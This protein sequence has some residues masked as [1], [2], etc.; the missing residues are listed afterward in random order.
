MC[1][2]PID[3]N[4]YSVGIHRAAKVKQNFPKL[5]KYN[6][7]HLYTHSVIYYD[8]QHVL[9]RL[10][11]AVKSNSVNWIFIMQG[12]SRFWKWLLVAGC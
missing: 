11:Q 12:M 3:R 6:R 4:S 8:G 1:Q 2:V 10:K 5:R 9:L 7:S